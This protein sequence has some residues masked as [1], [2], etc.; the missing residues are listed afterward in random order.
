MHQTRLLAR[1]F[2]DRLFE[3]DLMPEGLPQVQLVLWSVLLAATPTT[4]MPLVFLKKYAHDQFYVPLAPEMAADRTIL[5]TLSMMAIGVVGLFIWDGVFPDQRDVRI[6]GPLPIQTRRFVVARLAALGR[7]YIM[8]STVICV[9]QSLIFG[10]VVAGYGDPVSR[11]H[12]IAAHLLTVFLACTFIFCALI[13]A[14]C[15]LLLMF[16]RRVALTASLIFQLLFAV[17]LVQLVFF[18]PDLGRVLREG[19]GQGLA[20]IATLPP[21]WFFGLYE[22]L[23]GTGDAGAAALARVA[24]G[25]TLL[26][27]ALAIGLYATSYDLLA[28]RALEGAA[29]RSG[30][31]KDRV[32][33]LSLNSRQPLTAAVREFTVKTLARSRSHRMMFAIYA[34]VALAFVI[35]S[36]VSVLFRNAE[37][38]IWKPGLAMLSMP[39]I[40][41]FI[42]LI[43]V[44][45]ITSVPSEPK[46]RWVFRAC[47]PAERTAAIN[48]LR[49]TMMN[50]VVFPSVVFALTQGLIFWTAAAA[51]SHAVFCFVVG[52]LFA[53]V[54]LVNTDKL[55]FACTYFPGKSR[56]FA[57]WPL[58]LVAFF[59]FAIGFGELDLVLLSR[60][61]SL[62]MWCLFLTLLTQ[63]VSYVRTV[64]LDAL[65]ALRFEEE[66]PDRMFQGFNLSEGIAAERT[67]QFRP[68][69]ASRITDAPEY[70]AARGQ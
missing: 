13:A 37:A 51:V 15:L 70:P 20:A 57:L 46:A 48:G 2:F 17:A 21:T 64:M 34:G 3:S 35:S 33:Q 7:V 55:P 31:A 23:S 25:S 60:Y 42:M 43:A 38:G 58:Y 10:L 36:A 49:D 29:P 27:I 61:R 4:A 14:Q 50:V 47:E 32:P 68:A 1:A 63:A 12:G 30:K 19:S 56:V 66:D 18:L 6:L 22:T 8:F 11:P 9:L 59:G 28:R 45:V 44:R 40:V 39:L 54:L 65:P 52:R 26:S 53:E 69:T 16:G 67:P 41:Q 5:I 24:T 62:V